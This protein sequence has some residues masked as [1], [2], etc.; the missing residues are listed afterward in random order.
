MSAL[1]AS[2]GA[3]PGVEKLNSKWSGKVKFDLI[4]IILSQ[5]NITFYRQVVNYF[6]L[7]I[8]FFWNRVKYTF[9]P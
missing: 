8:L 7:N 4:K 1:G 2:L 9:S 3:A 5:K 6:E